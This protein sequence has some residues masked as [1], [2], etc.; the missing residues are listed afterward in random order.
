MKHCP[1]CLELK[2]KTIKREKERSH[3]NMYALHNSSFSPLP[4]SIFH[5]GNIHQ[6]W[7]LSY[8]TESKQNK[9][10]KT[11]NTHKIIEVRVTSL[12]VL[13]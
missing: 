3:P 7:K 2:H 11:K 9:P 12:K 6:A 4:S 13:I 8:K 1:Q 5:G 10:N